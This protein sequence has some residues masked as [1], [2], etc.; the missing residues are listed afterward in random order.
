PPPTP[1]TTLTD[2]DESSFEDLSETPA[3]PPSRATA[4]LSR[5]EQMVLEGRAQSDAELRAEEADA[6]ERL[7][8][9]SATVRRAEHAEELVRHEREARS[10]LEEE[11]LALR[12][13]VAQLTTELAA[14][15]DAGDRRVRDEE[16]R[17]SAA[18]RARTELEA[19]V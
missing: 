7:E 15:R 5:A 12:D 19:Q 10:A 2:E 6:R 16:E 8:R 17:A 3:P 4:V 9:E 1:A 14:E 11:V 13:Q 18:Q